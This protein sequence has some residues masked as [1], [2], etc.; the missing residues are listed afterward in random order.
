LSE[1]DA[2]WFICVSIFYDWSFVLL[3]VVMFLH[4]T[5]FLY[6]TKHYLKKCYLKF[7]V[8]TCATFH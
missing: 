2:V 1:F 5:I 3:Q 4:E 6:W 8:Y 7:V